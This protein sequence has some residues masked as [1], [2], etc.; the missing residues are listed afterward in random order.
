MNEL[1]SKISDL[2]NELSKA[3][4]TSINEKEATIGQLQ[5]HVKSLENKIFVHE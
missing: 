5:H 1:E 3:H 2:E 4:R